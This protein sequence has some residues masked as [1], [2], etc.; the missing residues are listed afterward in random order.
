MNKHKLTNKLNTPREVP[1]RKDKCGCGMISRYFVHGAW[2]CNE[3]RRC[4]T[5][6]KKKYDWNVI[7]PAVLLL[8]W[9]LTVAIM[10]IVTNG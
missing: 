6:H 4:L 8:S 3:V 2:S 1:A 10:S 9:I 5:P 7:I